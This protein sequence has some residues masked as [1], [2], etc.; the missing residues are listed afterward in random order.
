[1]DIQVL[2]SGSSGNSYRVSDGK[3]SLLL[4]AGIPLQKIQVAIHFKL[5]AIDGCLITHEHMDHYKAADD[6]M[7][8][9]ILVCTS[10]GTADERNLGGH[11]LKIVESLKQ[12][13]IG[14]FRILPFDVQHDAAE[15]L[16]FLIES[17][18]TGDKLLY[19]TDTYFLKYK[20]NGLTHIMGECN[21]D[22]RTLHKNVRDKIITPDMMKRLVKSHMSFERFVSFLQSN[23]L[24]KVRQIY[25]LH[26]SKDNSNADYYKKEIQKITGKEVYIA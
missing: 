11:N 13:S 16:G 26:L 1:M 3:T 22:E 15:P 18:H 10:K 7:K 21:Y 2:A 14:T 23:D 8:R 6:L 4:D 25:L 9:G 12:I 24:S 20:F 19:F 5:S 17:S